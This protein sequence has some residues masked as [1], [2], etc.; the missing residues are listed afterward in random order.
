MRQLL[1]EQ[2]DPMDDL[3]QQQGHHHLTQPHH[4]LLRSDKGWLLWN[5][6][7]THVFTHVNVCAA[8][9]AGLLV[10]NEETSALAC[11][12]RLTLSDNNQLGHKGLARKCC[13][14]FVVDRQARGHVL[15]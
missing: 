8:I 12:V 5:R 15:L 10:F 11:F 7:A 14:L 4:E 6:W 13:Q 9:H 2:D 3:S 1:K